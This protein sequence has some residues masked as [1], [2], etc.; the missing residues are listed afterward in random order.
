MDW[1]LSSCAY[2][3]FNFWYHSGVRIKI[4]YAKLYLLHQVMN[5]DAA[6]SAATDECWRDRMNEKSHTLKKIAQKYDNLKMQ[7]IIWKSNCQSCYSAEDKFDVLIND[8]WC[9]IIPKW[10]NTYAL[11]EYPC[12][13]FFKFNCTM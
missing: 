4:L 10:S 3:T 9:A 12:I 11:S 8:K 7:Y 5:D 6:Q 1:V 2:Y 13:I